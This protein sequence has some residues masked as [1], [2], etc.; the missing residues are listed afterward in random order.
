[1]QGD[2]TVDPEGLSAACIAMLV[3]C[4]IAA[5]IGIVVQFRT[6]R[7]FNHKDEM[8]KKNKHYIDIN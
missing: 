1:M 7:T 6:F 2:T 5:L 3:C 8:E 4:P